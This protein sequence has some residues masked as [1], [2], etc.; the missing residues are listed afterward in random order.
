MNA[1]FALPLMTAGGGESFMYLGDRFRS[2]NAAVG[3]VSVGVVTAVAIVIVTL[4]W[5]FTRTRH[6]E[7]KR[8]INHPWKLMTELAQAHRLSSQQQRLLQRMVRHFSVEPPARIFLEPERFDQAIQEATFQSQT[9]RL[10]QLK[11]RLFGGATH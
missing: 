6:P 9:P 2:E 5:L 1:L 10:A 11:E 8:P 7:Q 4:I 3:P